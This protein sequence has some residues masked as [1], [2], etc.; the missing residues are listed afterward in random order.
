[1]PE[2]EERGKEMRQAWRPDKENSSPFPL[3]ICG[4]SVNRRRRPTYKETYEF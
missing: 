2:R 3:R 1:M 4:N